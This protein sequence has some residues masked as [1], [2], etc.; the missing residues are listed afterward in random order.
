MSQI[1]V[2]DI[3]PESGDIVNINEIAIRKENNSNIGLGD[4]NTL[5]SITTGDGNIGFGVNAV[6]SVSAGGTVTGETVF[7][8]GLTGDSIT[9]ESFI[10]DGS[11]LSGV[12]GL[13]YSDFGFTITSSSPSTINQNL[14]LPYNVNMEYSGPLT[15]DNGVILTI[16]YGTTLTI[17]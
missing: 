7:T 6:K 5:S 8:N 3:L 15:V 11:R 10:G 13:N 16:P 9:S 12:V 17:L 1:N 2:N 4:S 14:T